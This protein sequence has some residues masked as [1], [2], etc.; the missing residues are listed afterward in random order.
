[1]GAS[2]QALGH[3]KPP[4]SGKYT[5]VH[6]KVDSGF[7]EKRLE[8]QFDLSKLSTSSSCLIRS[9]SNALLSLFNACRRTLPPD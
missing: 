2:A 8:E 5:D 4:S 1:M 3:K 7:N 9:N 6:S